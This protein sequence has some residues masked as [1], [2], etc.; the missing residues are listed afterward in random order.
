VSIEQTDKRELSEALTFTTSIHDEMDQREATGGLDRLMTPEDEMVTVEVTVKQVVENV[1][2]ATFKVTVPRK[3][4]ENH[5]VL[6]QA[7][8][9]QVQDEQDAVGYGEPQA[10]EWQYE[11]ELQEL[12][13][14]VLD[15]E[16]V[17]SKVTG[18]V[19]EDE[20]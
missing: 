9:E 14:D 10:G 13:I 5:D 7:C 11:H 6:L 2:E 8:D 12:A 19:E 4:A 20:D 1:V 17:F 3:D 15:S 16:V 18:T